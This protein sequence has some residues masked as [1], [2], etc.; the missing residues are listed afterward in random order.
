MCNHD[1]KKEKTRGIVHN[2]NVNFNFEYKLLNFDI[3]KGGRLLRLKC[4]VTDISTTN[5]AKVDASIRYCGC[6]LKLT[7]VRPSQA[8][9]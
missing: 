9:K 5:L 4:A 6:I 2:K 8:A 1:Y 7:N 3:Q